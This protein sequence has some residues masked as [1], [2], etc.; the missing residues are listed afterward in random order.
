MKLGLF[1]G[2]AILYLGLAGSP[3]LVDDDFDAAHALVAREM[4][5]RNDFVV[6]YQ[7]GLRYLIRP[8]LHFWL[9][10]G[11]YRMLGE[12]EWS[13][14]LPL[15]LACVGMVLLTFSFGRRFFGERAGFYGALAIATSAGMYVFTRTVMPDAIY[16]LELLAVFY[17]FLRSWTGSLDPRLGYPAAAAACALA[18]LTRGPIGFLFPAAT[19]VGFL[20]LSGSWR[21]WRQLQLLP[22]AAVFLAIAVPW[23]VLAAL[24]APGFLWVYFVNEHV[25]RALGT[26]EPR[27]Y[28][29]VPLW[30]WL[31]EHLLWLFPWSVFAPLLTRAFPP[32][33][34]WRA[35]DSAAGQAR[36][37]LITWV[38]VIVGFFCIESGSRMEYYSLGAWPAL[39]L[40]LGLGLARA[41]EKH[42]PRA[43]WIARALAAFAVLYAAAAAA[44]L[45]AFGGGAPA[46]IAGDLQTRDSAD[47]LN[48]MSRIH[49]LTPQAL[50]DLRW[51]IVASV[52]FLLAGF[53][54]AWRLRERERF[55]TAAVAMALGMAGVFAAANMAYRA[56]EP[57]MSSRSLAAALAPELHAGD[58]V[59]LYGDIRFAPGIAF[60]GHRRVL[61]VG[62]VGSEL[63]FGSRFADAPKTLYSPDEFA[64][65]WNGPGRVV[66]VAPAARSDE[67]RRL[68][69]AKRLSVLASIGGKV[70]YANRAS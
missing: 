8:P 16:A 4:L 47:Y 21:R 49:D 43:N 56:L 54:S 5:Q 30:L 20:T 27:D 53:L 28:S 36:L 45:F 31:P 66:L 58:R 13:T 34:A 9:I 64:A 63:V 62:A 35:D 6:M 33:R 37:L 10:A 40:L 7:D 67:I 41:E 24:R 32:V 50:A 3:A 69:S 23:H 42:D 1:V 12:S 65:L 38:G 29:A 59:A 11:S 18:V 14:R 48:A 2:S 61:L 46:A 44:F 25:L 52:A 55:R 22:S 57:S 19:V 68:L 15:A 26:R 51:P 70:A 60:Y 39:A 17:L